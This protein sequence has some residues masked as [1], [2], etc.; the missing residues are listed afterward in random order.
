[1]C[2]YADAEFVKLGR[3]NIRNMRHVTLFCVLI[4]RTFLRRELAEAVLFAPPQSPLC[5][6]IGQR[7][8]PKKQIRTKRAS[9][10]WGR[11]LSM[12][13]INMG[14]V[15]KWTNNSPPPLTTNNFPCPL[16]IKKKYLG[17][18]FRLGF[19]KYQIWFSPSVIK[20]N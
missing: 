17:L 7:G 1:M 16:R 2:V 19:T 5:N 11:N 12:V 13:M 8:D 10:I 4:L 20:I 18:S 3:G 6:R 15:S 9:S 14:F